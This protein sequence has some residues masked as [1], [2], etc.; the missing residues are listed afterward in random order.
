[1]T[2]RSLPLPAAVPARFH[3]EFWMKSIGT[4]WL[5]DAA[6]CRA[7]TLRDVAALQALFNRII[8]E[9]RLCPIGDAVWHRFP[10]AGGVTGFAL[11]AE[12]HLAG[13]TWPEVGAA[14]I[15]LFCCD[16]AKEP[17]R[18]WPWDERLRE[19][20]GAERV[21]VRVIERRIDSD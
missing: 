13:H 4:E 14:A 11:L 16:A 10:G 20:L 2:D 18:D 21:T 9:L 15:N 1:M 7:E 5:I 3:R 17:R 19:A 12:S 8:A 6:G